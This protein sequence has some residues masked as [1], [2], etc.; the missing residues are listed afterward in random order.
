MTSTLTLPRRLVLHFD[1]N[2]TITPIDTTEPGSKVDNANMV[3]AKSVYGHVI[4]GLIW[5]PNSDPY[6]ATEAISY[7]DHLKNIKENYKRRS[8]SFTEPGQPGQIFREI[9][10]PLVQAMDDDQLLFGSFLQVLEQFPAALIV[11]RTF[12]FDSDEMIKSIRHHHPKIGTMV[13]GEFVPTDEACVLKM[14]DTDEEYNGLLSINELLW[15]SPNHLV[16]R[17]NYQYW[18]GHQRDRVHG[19]QLLGSPHMTQIF[20]DDNDCV[21]VV[22]PTNAHFMRI[23]TLAAMLDTTYYVSKIHA[24]LS[25]VQ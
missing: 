14:D 3:I 7:Y 13:K 1:I 8:F 24:I 5:C 25:Q 15:Q 22:D 21:N 6:D 19:K 11:L 17:E 4:D 16:L 9:V 12:G 18:N 20:F 10:P 2:G 23:N